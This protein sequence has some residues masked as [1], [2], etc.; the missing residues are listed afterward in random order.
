MKTPFQAAGG[1]RCSPPA[2]RRRPVGRGDHRAA[3]HRAAGRRVRVGR[4]GVAAA[5]VVHPGPVRRLPRR[6]LRGHLREVL[7]RRRRSSRAVS[8]SCR[9]RCSPTAVPTSRPR[10]CP[11]RCRPARAAPTSCNI[12][13][14]FQRSGTL[15]CRSR[16]PASQSPADLEGR[17]VEQLGLRQRVRDLRRRSARPASTR[18]DVTHVAAGRRHDPAASRGRSTPPRR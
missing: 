16:T 15:R 2:R 1:R 4:R 10:G 12:A 17:T 5:A 14:I 3:S 9:S 7:P 13:Q 11:R 8:T 18:R 6:R